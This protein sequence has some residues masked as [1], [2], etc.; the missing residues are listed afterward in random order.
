[1]KLIRYKN[2][3]VLIIT[4]FLIFQSCC[5]E[6]GFPD[7]TYSIKTAN[8]DWLTD[9]QV[10]DGFIMIDSNNISTFFK[11]YNTDQHYTQS[12]SCTLGIRTHS[13][14]R[15]YQQ[16]SFNST[17]GIPFN[18]SIDANFPP[19][20]NK[21]W[22]NINQTEFVVD[23]DYKELIEVS[24]NGEFHKFKEED[25]D[26]Y[27][28]GDLPILSQIRYIDTLEIN[29]HVFLDILHFSLLD[30]TD[31]YTNFTVKDIY[32]AKNKGIIQYSLQNGLVY[33]RIE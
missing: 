32:I 18:I 1:M 22:I 16:Q 3:V 25:I 24:L 7:D 8:L 4:I 14:D 11:L 17:F 12:Y 28:D 21:L 27:I 30:F 33:K 29:G 15:E 5:P 23:L 20:G 13:S 6:A 10:D 26:S 19:F 31:K 9:Y 2:K